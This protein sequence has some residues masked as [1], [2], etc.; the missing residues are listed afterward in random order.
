MQ[1]EKLAKLGVTMLL[2]SVGVVM[3]GQSTPPEWFTYPKQGEYVGV[4]VK[5]EN[6]VGQD[7]EIKSAIVSALVSYFLQNEMKEVDFRELITSM[8]SAERSKS[9]ALSLLS[10][11][12]ALG[13]ELVRM[14]KD[15]DGR[16]WVAI[17]PVADNEPGTLC[18]VLLMGEGATEMVEKNG[19][20]D[21]Y[22]MSKKLSCASVHGKDTVEIDFTWAIRKESL[23]D[24]VRWVKQNDPSSYPVQSFVYRVETSRSGGNVGLDGKKDTLTAEP[25]KEPV[26]MEWMRKQ[27]SA[28]GYKGISPNSASLSDLGGG[29]LSAL[30]ETLMKS[31][32]YVI[33][34]ETKQVE[35]KKATRT[36]ATFFHEGECFIF[37]DVMD[38]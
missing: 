8:S 33:N 6:R 10:S 2:L 37:N 36:Y 3:H 13:Y 23:S 12:Y 25:S 34:P 22:N 1:L 18:Q 35:R 16:V 15:A 9:D 5:M 7:S 19:V 29:Y 21:S 26:P 14:E 27:A 4:S 20:V 30:L 28:K 38:E 32:L 24:G 31:E 17:R 11:K